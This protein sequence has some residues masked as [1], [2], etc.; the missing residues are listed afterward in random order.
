V[1]DPHSVTGPR[2]TTS[3]HP[4]R[5][6]A[7]APGI[8]PLPPEVSRALGYLVQL[9]DEH[10][11][12]IV[13]GEDASE[14]F[15]L[16]AALL[17]AACDAG[18]PHRGRGVALLLDEYDVLNLSMAAESGAHR[19]AV[20]MFWRDA[21]LPHASGR[22]V[23]DVT[24]L[25]GCSRPTHRGPCRY[26]AL[27]P[28]GPRQVALPPSGQ[29][30]PV[31]SYRVERPAALGPVRGASTLPSGLAGLVE[32]AAAHYFLRL[33]PEIP[34]ADRHAYLVHAG[35][36]DCRTGSEW[37]H[38]RAAERGLQARRAFGLLLTPPYANQHFL[39]SVPS[40]SGPVEVDPLLVSALHRWGVV[41]AGELAV[42]AALG[43]VFLPL[44]DGWAPVLTHNGSLVPD[45]TIVVRRP[46]AAIARGGTPPGRTGPDR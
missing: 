26:E 7:G 2:P 45:P 12:F 17:A 38:D 31:M 22:A 8:P 24:Y 27:T 37:L 39:C 16:D 41:T 18:L 34:D 13:S 9:A 14:R 21:F 40:A 11:R 29:R 35:A 10:R 33:S 32:E 36:T 15:G 3:P 28:G 1:V 6:T 23:Y 5:A 30:R 43:H 44:A 42:G 20:T 19:R 4:A 25:A 46:R